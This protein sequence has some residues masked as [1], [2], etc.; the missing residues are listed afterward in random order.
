MRKLIFTGIQNAMQR[1]SL[2][3]MLLAALCC[4]S[5]SAYGQGDSDSW[6]TVHC[7]EPGQL[8]ERFIQATGSAE[9]CLQ[10][11]HLKVTGRLGGADR[12]VFEYMMNNIM[13]LDMGEVES[14]DNSDRFYVSYNKRRL[15]SIIMP[16]GLTTYL[17][18]EGCDS[19]ES[20]VG[21]TAPVEVGYRSFFG[22]KWLTSIDLPESVRIISNQAFCGCEN[23]TRVTM[24]PKVKLFDSDCFNGCKSLTDLTIPDSLEEISFAA[25]YATALNHITLPEGC[26]VI[27][28]S[29]FA[30]NTTLTTV[31]MPRE[32]EIWTNNYYNSW[33]KGCTSLINVTLPQ[34][35]TILYDGMF[36]DC[37]SLQHVDIP[38]SVTAFYDNVFSGCSQLSDLNIPENVTSIGGGCFR[39]TAITEITTAKWPSRLTEITSNSFQNCQKL[40]SVDLRGSNV[41]KIGSSA[42]ADCKQL[43]SIAL[44]EDLKV[45]N[46]YLCSGCENL[47]SVVMPTAPV[48]ILNDAFHSCQQLK[49]IDLPVSLTEIGAWAFYECPME[50]VTLPPLVTRYEPSTFRFTKLRHVVVPEG[51]TY[52]GDRCFETDSLRSVDIP[53]TIKYFVG[54]PLGDR[55]PYLERVTF[56][57]LLPPEGAFERIGP[58]GKTT[59]LVP[60]ATLAVWKNRFQDMYPSEK[61]LPIEGGYDPGL[62]VVPKEQVFNANQSF[63]DRARNVLVTWNSGA[64][65]YCS[66]KLL[67][68]PGGALKAD[69]YTHQYYIGPWYEDIMPTMI[70]HGGDISARRVTLQMQP[71]SAVS[72]WWLMTPAA[73]MK[74]SDIE[75]LYPNTPFVIKRYDSQARATGDFAHTWRTVGPDETLRAGEGF[76]FRHDYAVA[77]DEY[78]EWTRQERC[79]LFFRSEE[80]A[81]T[82]VFRSDDVTL[83]LTDS[84]GEFEHNR[85]WNLVGNPWLSYFDIRHLQ[86]EQPIF[87]YRG[88]NG[89]DVLSPLD[90]DFVLRPLQGFFVQYT[91]A[92][93]TLSFGQIGRQVNATINHQSAAARQRLRAQMRRQRTVYD[94]TLQHHT[95]YGRD[96]LVARTR[97]VVNPQATL[98]YDSGKDAPLMLS[99]AP[100]ASLIDEH[101]ASPATLF[102]LAG[103]VQYAINER[104]LDNGLVTLA[105]TVPEAGTYS[106]SL[107][108]RGEASQSAQLIDHEEGI[109]VSLDDAPY[110]FTTD[111]GTHLTRFELCLGSDAVFVALPSA[112]SSTCSTLYDLQGRPVANA[113]RGIY[114]RDGRKLIIK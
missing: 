32:I 53:S 14:E 86:T 2:R 46:Q 38:A 85:G 21:P 67:V 42:F 52:L 27:K 22:C 57:M 16:P 101:A 54:F 39:G 15:R 64:N 108:V 4:L 113:K 5:G 95:E 35:L 79:D 47:S 89:F 43:Q 91:E 97:V 41:K 44:P 18:L 76:F 84:R 23:L 28:N 63:G 36:Q 26:K 74:M 90:D 66:G 88:N 73:D 49:N 100:D 33:F 105:Y 70:N 87:I 55:I 83:P 71:Y 3:T 112:Q 72:T 104:P 7:D 30:N 106:I 13:Y 31:V 93:P 24:S 48:K 68:E 94:A 114:I 29:A 34:N 1:H 19:I 8:G 103:G 9:A 109:T 56:R 77:R 65:W 111:A 96:T 10:V 50:E 61:I 62:V 11:T 80:G 59:I 82:Y 58:L 78:G 6:V 40:K 92:Q 37:A 75:T 60:Q 17:S 12:N 110:S 45:I 20:F 99:G 102:T 107:R 51:V 25:L 69:T 98:A 81:N